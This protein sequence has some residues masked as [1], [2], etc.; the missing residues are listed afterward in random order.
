MFSTNLAGKSGTQCQHD[1]EKY[2]TSISISTYIEEPRQIHILIQA[3]N[4]NVDFDGNACGKITLY[5][6]NGQRFV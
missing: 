3:G 4:G 6:D 2:Q 1:T 5:F